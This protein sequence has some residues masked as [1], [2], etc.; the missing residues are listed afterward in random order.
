MCVD[1]F[2]YQDA[3][4][5]TKQEKENTSL[6]CWTS[7]RLK[8]ISLSLIRKTEIMWMEIGLSMILPL[9]YCLWAES[10]IISY[11]QYNHTYNKQTQIFLLIGPCCALYTRNFCT[12]IWI[13]L[14]WLK[15]SSVRKF[16]FIKDEEG[17]E[18]Y[19][20]HFHLCLVIEVDSDTRMSIVQLR[21]VSIENSNN[22]I[23]TSFSRTDW[24]QFQTNNTH[25]RVLTSLLSL[26]MVIISCNG[27]L[28]NAKVQVKPLG[29]SAY[30]QAFNTII[31]AL[32][33]LW[34][35]VLRLLLLVSPIFWESGRLISR[36]SIGMSALLR[37]GSLQKSKLFVT[38][39]SSGNMRYIQCKCLTWNV[40]TLLCVSHIWP[41]L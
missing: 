31:V 16:L 37:S 14:A 39:N 4:T 15:C 41:C 8:F 19:F 30:L 13:N 1:H 24:K 32:Q 22:I 9:K 18:K 38:V 29:S 40:S 3:E 10:H 27:L 26:E 28:K 21:P 5:K 36:L 23:K 12:K 20:D 35:T 34:A 17:E 11:I 6:I 33:K 7:E 25:H 2:R